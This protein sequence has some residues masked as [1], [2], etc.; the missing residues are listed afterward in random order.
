MV[1]KVLDGAGHV[2]RFASVR[3]GSSEVTEMTRL[4]P[5][6]RRRRKYRRGGS[7]RWGRRFTGSSARRRTRLTD[8]AIRRHA[9]A[10][11]EGVKWRFWHGRRGRGLIGVVHLRQ[12]AHARC[13]VYIPAM[14]K[15]G[16]ALLDMIR[17]LEANADSL[18]NY[19]QRYRNR[20]RISTDLRN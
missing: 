1:G 12:W 13:F 5:A 9:L 17:Y 10:Q 11:L 16:T 4:A 3:Q 7:D 6:A 8:G 15:L 20:Q 19:G 14:E 18:P 2:T